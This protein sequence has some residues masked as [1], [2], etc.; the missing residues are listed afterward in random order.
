MKSFES[1]PFFR[2]PRRYLVA[3]I[4]GAFATALFS[5]CTRPAEEDANRIL[6]AFWGSVQQQRAEE[7]MVRAFQEENPDITVDV[8]AIGSRY[9][10]MIQAMMVGHVAPDVIMV[11]MAYYDEWATRGVLLELTGVYERLSR[12]NEFMPIVETAYF[13]EDGIF[14]L[15]TN[16]HARA[17][18]YNQDALAQAGV[19]IPEEGLS[20]DFLLEVGPRLSR[21]AGNPD[22]PTDF[23]FLM[24]HYAIFFWQHGA[25]FFDDLHKPTE[26]TIDTPEAVAALEF[27]RKLMDTGF[28][29][30]TEVV[31][32]EGSYQLFR[33]GRLAFFFDGR[34]RTPEFDGATTFDWDVAAFPRGP[35]SA[36]NHHGGTALGVWKHSPRRE[37]ARRF[38]EFY[39][40]PA[41]AR[42]N[43]Q[44]QRAVPVF[45]ELAYGEEFLS[46]RPP[47][48]MRPF[49]E[50]MEADAS[51]AMLYAPGMQEVQRIFNS[52]MEQALADDRRS[53][54]EIIRGLHTDLERWLNRMVERGVL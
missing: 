47:E 28:V 50:T 37:A 22:A 45:R 43:M 30:P 54:G 23:A 9:P 20:W 32:D 51:L 1:A 31:A 44:G 11:E 6:F 12:E 39:A 16:C 19:V 7:K 29:V 15:P 42:I 26:V 35:V 3:G 25:R 41:G 52:R 53:S 36:M 40:S 14:A 4:L 46:L 18:Y 48:N 5:G 13:R 38:V 27:I 33:D 34:W 2:F 21:R 10:E 24:P 17:T 8:M 49:S